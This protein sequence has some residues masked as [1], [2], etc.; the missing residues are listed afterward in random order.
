MSMMSISV[1]PKITTEENLLKIASIYILNHKYF[2]INS[3]TH[4]I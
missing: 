2:T 4:S 1:L 3:L